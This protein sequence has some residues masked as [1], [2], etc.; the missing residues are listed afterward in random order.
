MLTAGWSGPRHNPPRLLLTFQRPGAY[1]RRCAQSSLSRS[2]SVQG[3]GGGRP[4]P[5]L[6]YQHSE[7]RTHSHSQSKDALQILYA[8][9]Q[10]LPAIPEFTM[11]WCFR[12][13]PRYYGI[14][15]SASV[16]LSFSPFKDLFWGFSQQ[17]FPTFSKR[18]FSRFNHTKIN[19]S[20]TELVTHKRWRCLS[21]SYLKVFLLFN[22]SSPFSAN[23]KLPAKLSST[24]AQIISQWT[25]SWWTHTWLYC[26]HPMWL[27]WANPVVYH[28]LVNSLVLQCHLCNNKWGSRDFKAVWWG[29]RVGIE[30]PGGVRGGVSSSNAAQTSRRAKKDELVVQA[31]H[32]RDGLC[33]GE[34]ATLISQWAASS[35]C[36]CSSVAFF[37]TEN[38][39]SV[40]SADH[41]RLL[42]VDSA[43][44]PPFIAPRQTNKDQV[45]VLLLVRSPQWDLITI[46]KPLCCRYES[47]R[48]DTLQ[49]QRLWLL[50]RNSHWGGGINDPHWG[51]G[52]GI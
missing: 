4:W 9:A 25:I 47:S 32:D 39:H 8:Q 43:G 36:R 52:V 27:C 49:R 51:G 22:I 46:L 35:P 14:V 30:Q 42:G 5:S 18:Y 1:P 34:G 17:P 37:L 20:C 48:H 23:Q 45:V 26:E 12:R 11:M 40:V 7:K 2:S 44:V 31:L 19:L 13:F 29:D 16:I 28:T 10:L 33:G 24:W 6:P 3:S 38:V 41:S 21:L 50:H 15:F